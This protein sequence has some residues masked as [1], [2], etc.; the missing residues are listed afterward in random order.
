MKS[1]ISR[2]NIKDSRINFREFLLGADMI[3]QN[4]TRDFINFFFELLCAAK[5]GLSINKIVDSKKNLFYSSRY[6]WDSNKEGSNYISPKLTYNNIETTEGS[7]LNFESSFHH[8]KNL[9]NSSSFSN[10]LK[11]SQYLGSEMKPQYSSKAFK[12][13]SKKDL[14]DIFVETSNSFKNVNLPR[15]IFEQMIE[16]NI[17]QFKNQLE[18]VIMN[19][20]EEKNHKNEIEMIYYEIQKNRNSFEMNKIT[21]YY[22]FKM[23][24]LFSNWGVF[25]YKTFQTR[26]KSM[27][28]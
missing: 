4:N 17:E 7:K 25:D 14:V 5:Q 2:I 21:F 27:L 20:S 22:F 24:S 16:R 3:L 1:K 18:G 28:N 19:Q 12:F 13:L 11:Q 8:N 15:I 23:N 6:K 10:S 26:C 9:D